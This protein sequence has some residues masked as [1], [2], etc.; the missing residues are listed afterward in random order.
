MGST[1]TSISALCLHMHFLEVTFTV[2]KGDK[3]GML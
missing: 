3:F 2:I 1:Y